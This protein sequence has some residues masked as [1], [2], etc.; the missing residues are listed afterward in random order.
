M[1]CED[2][3]ENFKP[4]NGRLEAYRLPG[5]PGIR[6][7]GAVA[8]GN[9]ISRYYDS[10]LTKVIAHAPT[11]DEALRK[12]D[13]ALSEFMIRGIKTNIAFVVNVLRHPEFA[14]ARRRATPAAAAALRACAVIAAALPCFRGCQSAVL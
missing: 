12:L 5:G 2:P 13:R 1:T 3:G 6:L 9:V 8:A 14:E 11:Y 4:D 7:D 10:L